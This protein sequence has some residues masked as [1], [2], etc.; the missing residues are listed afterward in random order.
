MIHYILIN[1]SINNIIIILIIIN[2]DSVILNKLYYSPVQSTIYPIVIPKFGSCN[3]G[4]VFACCSDNCNM[5][6]FFK[7]ILKNEIRHNYYE[8]NE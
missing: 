6:D 8:L 2:I 4:N 1:I 5:F 7:F 3:V